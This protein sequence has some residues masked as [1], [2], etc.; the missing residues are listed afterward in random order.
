VT[1]ELASPSCL[2]CTMSVISVRRAIY[3]STGGELSRVPYSVFYPPPGKVCGCLARFPDLP[4]A[5]V[6]IWLAIIARFA[7]VLTVA[8][9]EL[10]EL[11][12][13]GPSNTFYAS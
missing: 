2:S 3:G 6:D 11:L 4:A 9:S 8:L 12:S 5:R 7:R 1:E 13:Q 10:L